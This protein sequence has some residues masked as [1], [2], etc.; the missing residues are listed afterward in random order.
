MSLHNTI[1]DKTVLEMIID[2]LQKAAQRLSSAAR[3][4]LAVRDFRAEP[5]NASY[6]NF[7]DVSRVRCNDLLAVK[8]VFASDNIIHLLRY[9]LSLLHD[10][11]A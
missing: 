3:P 8:S 2:V 6:T 9:Q 4:E 7:A 5:S 1:Q 11:Q 10:L